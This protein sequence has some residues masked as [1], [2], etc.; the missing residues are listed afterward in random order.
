VNIRIEIDN[1]KM[2]KTKKDIFLHFLIITPNSQK[3]ISM[4]M[5]FLKIKLK[6]VI[7]KR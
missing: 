7:Q 2:K 5:D 6:N 3:Y 4:F 1:R